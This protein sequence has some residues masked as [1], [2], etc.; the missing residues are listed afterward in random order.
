MIVPGGG[1]MA[2]MEAVIMEGAK[3]TDFV[4]WNGGVMNLWMGWS[5]D[6]EWE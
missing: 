3:I 1:G 2:C 4:I 6:W 5:L